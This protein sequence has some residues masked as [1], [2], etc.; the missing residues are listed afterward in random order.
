[1]REIA[2]ALI[3]VSCLL[4]A[5]QQNSERASSYFDSLVVAQ[6]DQLSKAK[7]VVV[8]KA[9]LRGK[10][11]QATFT[12]DSLAWER[13]LGIF[14]QLSVFERPAYRKLYRREDGLT[15][16]TSNLSVRRYEA[17]EKIP[18]SELRFYYFHE[19]KNL[20]KIDAVYRQQNLL[21]ATTRHL[22]LEFED[23]KGKPILTA[24]H[25][26]GVQKMFL[27]DSVKFSIRSE[28]TPTVD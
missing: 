23:V 9:T 19:F 4:V 8:K 2:R 11:D 13:E 16:A 15:D 14:R 5:C 22:T 26:E 25:I 18:V 20:K 21:Y 17:T 24:Y 12:P 28:I 1:M 6:V 27:S 10:E 3:A 7:A